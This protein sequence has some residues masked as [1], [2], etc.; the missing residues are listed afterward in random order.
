MFEKILVAVDLDDPEQTDKALAAAK[1]MGKDTTHYLLVTVIPPLAGGN[2]VASLLPKDYDAMVVGELTQTLENYAAKQFPGRE[3][4]ACRV[5]H[6]S[7]YEEI[8]CMA[9]ENGCDTV[10]LCA[11]RARSRA[12]GPNAARVA[13]YSG[14]SVFIVR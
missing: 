11:A 3:N 5:A 8:N 14:K 6:G 13:R 4:V 7:V 2:I 10:V 12:L 1:A 9:G